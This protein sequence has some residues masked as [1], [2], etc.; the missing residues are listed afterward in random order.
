MLIIEEEV[1]DY[2]D[3]LLEGQHIWSI[4]TICTLGDMLDP[5]RSPHLGSHPLGDDTIV[6]I[7]EMEHALSDHCIWVGGLSR[8]RV[9][10]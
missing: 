8:E 9:M 4:L 10:V 6:I 5:W 2:M 1:L 3:D 7:H